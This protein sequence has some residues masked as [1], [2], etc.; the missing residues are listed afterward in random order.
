MIFFPL[1]YTSETEVLRNKCCVFPGHEEACLWPR[2]E[3]VK[4]VFRAAARDD[5][6][7]DLLQCWP[8]EL[9]PVRDTDQYK[10]PVQLSTEDD[11]FKNKEL[12]S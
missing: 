5:L 11:E 2:E 1:D 10:L 3:T 12:A 6:T 7:E 4:S 9:T 8:M